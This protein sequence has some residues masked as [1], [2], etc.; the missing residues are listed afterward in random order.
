M[1][2]NKSKDGC[3]WKGSVGTLS[4]H[5]QSCEFDL[6]PCKYKYI[7]CEVKMKK[8]DM[9]KHQQQEDNHHLH[10]ALQSVVVPTL[11]EGQSYA[12]ELTDYTKK[13]EN[14][15]VFISDPFYTHHKGYK[16]CVKVYANGTGSGTGSNISA[17][18]CV[19]QGLYDKKLKWPLQGVVNIAL[20]NQ[21]EDGYHGVLNIGFNEI[22]Q[23]LSP[24]KSFCSE[25]FISHLELSKTQERIL[26]LKNDI[27]YFQVTVTL[28]SNPPWLKCGVTMNNTV[29]KMCKQ[30]AYREPATFKVRNFAKLKKD[31]IIY[32]YSMK[33]SYHGYS[34]IVKVESGGAESG[35]GTHVSVSI[36]IKSGGYDKILSWP[37]IGTVQVELLN[38]LADNN[39]H[40][41]LLKFTENDDTQVGYGL[42][43]EKFISHEEL[44]SSLNKQFL[45][46]D[47]LYFR[48]T[49]S[50]GQSKPWLK[51]SD[52]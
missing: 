21:F 1:R 50:V 37:F 12:F 19:L 31:S 28:P 36:Y 42:L 38:Q 41:K 39:H 16:M 14:N 22:S 48:V 45:M 9:E 49:V 26:Y 7:E 51:C 4:M 35:K 46:D 2:C 43:S 44:H 5:M 32:Q 34:V 10:L 17:S 25:K 40:S 23:K 52:D 3:L 13:K 33:T 15:E 20:L 6:V 8:K 27:L 18:L 29:E 47:T 30:L 11:S 24:G